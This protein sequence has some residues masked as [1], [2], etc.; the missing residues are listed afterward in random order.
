MGRDDGEVAWD[1]VFP[2]AHA[3]V[4]E[5]ATHPAELVL[6]VGHETSDIASGERKGPA[7]AAAAVEVGL[8]K[9]ADVEKAPIV[10]DGYG[11]RA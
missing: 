3:S 5:V 8:G 6:T 9:A 11:A 2:V 7:A 1:W 10:A 4:V